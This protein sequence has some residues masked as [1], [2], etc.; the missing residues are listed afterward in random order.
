[1]GR[2]FFAAD[3]GTRVGQRSFE[4]AACKTET[5]SPREA[6]M[7]A[8]LVVLC[9]GVLAASI[10]SGS[11]SDA[12]NVDSP[13]QAQEVSAVGNAAIGE[14]AL[15]GGLYPA[16]EPRISAE[17]SDKNRER[18]SGAFQ[19]ALD[20]V[21]EVPECRELFTALG[22]DGIDTIAKIYFTPIG[23]DGAKANVCDGSVAYTFVGGGP[24][25]LCRKFS[26][27]TDKQAAM[28]IIHEALHHAGL[29]ERPRDPNGMPSA[30]INRMVSKRCGL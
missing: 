2:H 7:A 11:A 28:I 3:N 16:F 5:A 14:A 15:S 4:P 10:S 18:I 19:V 24:T 23:I 1:M 22:A 30:G 29:T 13:Y 26:R 17:M 21:G 9:V 25:W 12:I 27:L 20:R 8:R 6:F